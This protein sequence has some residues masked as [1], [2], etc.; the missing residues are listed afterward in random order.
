M[1]LLAGFDFIHLVVTYGYVVVALIVALESMGLPLPGETVLIAAAVYAGVTHRLSIVPL[2][3]AAAFGA[4]LGDNLGF[5]IGRRFGFALLRRYGHFVGLDERRLK[6][7]RY[8]FDR[9][10]GKVVSLAASPRCY[11][12]S[13]QCSPA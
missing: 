4:V 11:A 7:G 12:P 1:Q 2:I 3:G 10:G 5:W 9:H 8:L 13:P 6:L